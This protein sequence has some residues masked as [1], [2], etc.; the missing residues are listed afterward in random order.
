M[1][2]DYDAEKMLEIA[3]VALHKI[4]NPIG[5]AVKYLEAGTLLGE[6]WRY[7]VTSP[8]YISAVASEALDKIAGYKPARAPL[9][10]MI[11][12]FGKD[13]KYW[14]PGMLQGEY[15]YVH[16]ADNQI[17]LKRGLGAFAAPNAD[18]WLSSDWHLVIEGGTE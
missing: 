13:R 14:R 7:I 8:D 2:Y 15:A 17:Y 4:A 3:I 1:S 16:E 6:N 18:D 12:R 10:V 9:S 11:E 5:S